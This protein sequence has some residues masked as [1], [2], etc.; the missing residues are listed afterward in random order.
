[1]S[2]KFLEASGRERKDRSG[3]DSRDVQGKSSLPGRI[4]Q[5]FVRCEGLNLTGTT[6]RRILWERGLRM[7]RPWESTTYDGRVTT[8]TSV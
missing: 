2:R 6:K 7:V 5:G 1:M 8:F 4:I 3:R